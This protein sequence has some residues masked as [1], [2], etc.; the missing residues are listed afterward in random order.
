MV[1]FEFTIAGPPVSHQTRNRDRLRSWKTSVRNCAE[2]QLPEDFT[3]VTDEVTFSITY[4][5]EGHSPDVDNIIKPIQDAL[6]G[7]VFED[8]SQIC[9]TKSSKRNVNGSFRVRG[10]SPIVLTAFAEGDPFLHV[11]VESAP[12]MEVIE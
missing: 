10:I 11:R 7:L 1:L 8:D 9:V 5:Y 2:Q 4:Y 6:V 12:D 3:L